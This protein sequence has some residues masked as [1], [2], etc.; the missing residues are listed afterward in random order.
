[1]I[2]TVMNNK[3][4]T[5]DKLLEVRRVL[6]EQYITLLYIDTDSDADDKDL[7]SLKAMLTGAR[8]ILEGFAERLIKGK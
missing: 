8:G 7:T 2:N 5:I 1:M 4:E 3:Q 6:N